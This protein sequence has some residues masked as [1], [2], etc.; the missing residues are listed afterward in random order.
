MVP[1]TSY[2]AFQESANNCVR[3]L[4]TDLA[5][6]EAEDL[7]EAAAPPREVLHDA[8]VYVHLELEEVHLLPVGSIQG[9]Y[10][11]SFGNLNVS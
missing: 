8:A 11:P 9:Q 4:G 2:D 10:V 3:Y 5:S 1:I 6:A 7:E